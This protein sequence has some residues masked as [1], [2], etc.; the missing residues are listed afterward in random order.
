MNKTPTPT[1]E[2]LLTIISRLTEM[3]MRAHS[4][5]E[6]IQVVMVGENPSTSASLDLAKRSIWQHKYQP[7]LEKGVLGAIQAIILGGPVQ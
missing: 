1:P 5:L 2:Q 3:L 7:L 6:A 4:D